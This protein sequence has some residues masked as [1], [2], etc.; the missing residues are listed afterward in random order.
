M[1]YNPDEED[2]EEDLDGEEDEETELQNSHGVGFH[3][4]M[5]S[6]NPSDSPIEPLKS[7][8]EFQRYIEPLNLNS[9]PTKQQRMADM[10]LASTV[11]D[12][13][14]NMED[15][16]E[17]FMGTKA[18][19]G[20]IQRQDEQQF[21]D[22]RNDSRGVDTLASTSNTVPIAILPNTTNLPQVSNKAI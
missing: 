5:T 2:E 1:G 11:S 6:F 17:S 14:E 4:V 20:F 10:I 15:A 16:R 18:D 21:S 8:D 13:L 7:E 22:P 12:K 19:N 9:V 3:P